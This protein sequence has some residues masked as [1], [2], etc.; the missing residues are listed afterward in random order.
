MRLIHIALLSSVLLVGGSASMSGQADSECTF[1]NPVGQGQDPYVVRHGGVYS[2]IESRDNALYLYRSD[3]LTT[4][5]QNAV[6]VWEPPSD[7]WNR[8]HLWAP[9]LHFIDGLWYI[10]YAA[11]EAGPPFVHQRSG[12]L[13]STGSDPQGPYVDKGLLFTGDAK[14]DRTNVWAIDVTVGYIGERLY[15][16]WS[17]WQENEDTDKTPQHLYIAEMSDPWTISSERVRIS[18]PVEPWERGTELDLN[19]GPQ[20]LMRDDEVFIIYSARESW[21]KAY[22]LGQLRLK[23]LDADPMDPASWDKSGPVFTGTDEVY[24]VGHA[25]FTTSPDGTE[26]WIV[27]HAKVDETPGWERV[28]RMQSFGWNP[29]GSP[30]FGTPVASDEVVAVPSGQCE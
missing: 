29:D 27:Y 13:K 18:S 21:L 12:V 8:T 1:I 11:G 2:L 30:D 22:Q 14:G 3:G 24:G 20:F 15:A 5:K 6:K 9:E 4:I 28:I 26:D 19:E 7:G 25:S 10:Y 23:S 16:V 17:G